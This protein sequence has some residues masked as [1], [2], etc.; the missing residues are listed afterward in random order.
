MSIHKSEYVN[1]FSIKVYSIKELRN[2]YSISKNIFTKWLLPLK[3]EFNIGRRRILTVREVR[4]F[5][6]IH[7]IPGEV[8]LY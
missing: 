2:L 7:G 4:R 1:P 5:V 6:E 3:E 8:K